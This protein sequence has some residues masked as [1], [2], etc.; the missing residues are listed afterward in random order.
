MHYV[1]S[2]ET[3]EVILLQVGAINLENC[4]DWLRQPGEM[5]SD[6]IQMKH[7]R[8]RTCSCRGTAV[9]VLTVIGGKLPMLV[10]RGESVKS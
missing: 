4:T 1:I 10:R 8:Q 5:Q 9:V 2:L 6:Y 3:G 7:T